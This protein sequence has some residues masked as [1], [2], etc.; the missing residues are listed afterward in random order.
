MA[1]P[2]RNTIYEKIKEVNSL[3]K[4]FFSGNVDQ[5]F[6]KALELGF[7]NEQIANFSMDL[8]QTQTSYV[9]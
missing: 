1:I 3:Q 8:Q 7:D 4:D 5:A 9:S 6:E 2:L